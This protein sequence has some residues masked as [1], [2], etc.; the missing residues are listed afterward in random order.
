MAVL[1]LFGVWIM[2]YD[3]GN[4][5]SEI[6]ATARRDIVGSVWFSAIAITITLL[7]LA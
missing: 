6:R 7:I 5:E 2:R 4:I 1:L 3:K